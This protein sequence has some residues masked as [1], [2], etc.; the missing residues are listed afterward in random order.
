[1]I[2]PTISFAVST[3]SRAS[4]ADIG[5]RAGK[6]LDCTFTPHQDRDNDRGGAL[7]ARALGL[8]LVLSHDP[9]IPE[10]EERLFTLVG[11]LRDE[12]DADWDPD[13]ERIDLGEYV[14]GVLAL[15]DRDG[16]W[17]VDAPDAD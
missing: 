14:L 15:T 17:F 6:A 16:G 4:L 11:W 13:A 10:G 12:L 2:P 7:A 9:D 5:A 1:M 3:M 8:L